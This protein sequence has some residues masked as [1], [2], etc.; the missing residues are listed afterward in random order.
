[1]TMAKFR[2]SNRGL[3]KVSG[4][5]AVPFLDG[6][7]TNN[8]KRLADG[9]RMLAAFA[10]PQGRLIAI[11]RILRKGNEFFIETEAAT[12]ETIFRNLSRFVPAGEFFVED[13]SDGFRFFEIFGHCEVPDGAHDFGNYPLPGLFVP[14]ESAE[15]FLEWLESHGFT[16]I[17]DSEYEI[18]RIEQGVPL[19][20]IDV[21]ENTIVPEISLEGLISY[22]K[23]C[24]TGQEIIARIHFRGHV[25]KRLTGVIANDD[26][27][28][29]KPGCDLV[30]QD[31][32]NAG[33]VTSA[34]K[35]PKIGK[36]IGL[37]FVRYEFLASGTA[38]L[39]NGTEVLVADLPFIKAE[40]G[41]A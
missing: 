37:A 28:E 5:E 20:G 2:Q 39:C 21:D 12:H 15:A 18:K 22:Q 7:V 27:V 32:K 14:M 4:K 19:F 29:I 35:S 26:S 25:A 36:S 30:A 1:M 13:L 23:G 11:V 10:N 9:S 24:Y 16:P 31:G 40:T 41:E 17:S 34:V 38:L 6:L 33:R 3:I 8:V